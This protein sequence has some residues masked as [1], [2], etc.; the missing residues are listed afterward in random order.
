M[1]HQSQVGTA[2]EHPSCIDL[3][4]NW[5]IRPLSG[6][7]LYMSRPFFQTVRLILPYCD[8]CSVHD[9][10]CVFTKLVM[11]DGILPIS[12]VLHLENSK[13]NEGLRLQG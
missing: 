11:F 3:A 1:S 7:D 13:A 6:G 10:A 12:D 4:S 5:I 8:A 9:T 2:E